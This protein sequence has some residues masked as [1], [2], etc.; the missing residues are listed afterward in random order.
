MYTKFVAV[1][2]NEMKPL[3]ST[4]ALG[5]YPWV[6]TEGRAKWLFLFLHSIRTPHVSSE[7]AWT[8]WKKTPHSDTPQ[9]K[10]RPALIWRLVKH[11]VHGGKQGQMYKRTNPSSALG[12]VWFFLVDRS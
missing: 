7:S 8:A 5:F 10:R 11:L 4:L 3:N 12:A 9:S 1:E 2:S 6:S